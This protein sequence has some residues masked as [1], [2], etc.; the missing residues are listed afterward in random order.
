MK[1]LFVLLSLL[2][3]TGFGF[4]QNGFGLDGT[5][6]LSDASNG[7]IY[8]MQLEGRM[9][10]NDYLSTSVGV[11]L[12]NSGYKNGWREDYTDNTATMFRLSD[13]QTV[14]GLQLNTRGQLPLFNV[15]NH[16]VRLFVEPSLYFMPF[17]GRTVNLNETHLLKKVDS[18]TGNI[19]YEE[20]TVDPIS[21]SSLKSDSHSRFFWD[22][23]AASHP[24]QPFRLNTLSITNVGSINISTVKW[25]IWSAIWKSG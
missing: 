22:V 24:P 21:E 10:W 9:Q 8:S 15:S 20:R 18:G 7:Q 13:N 17:S 25:T 12:W 1:R 23:H 16:S 19:T 3:M 2:A 5:V 6:G 14:P 4:A 11:S